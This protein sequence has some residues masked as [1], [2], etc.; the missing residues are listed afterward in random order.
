[1][2]LN[3]RQKWQNISL[4]LSLVLSIYLIFWE[5]P[6]HLP[7]NQLLYS[8]LE[9]PADLKEESLEPIPFSSGVIQ[10]KA[11]GE[12][13]SPSPET[14]DNYL[15]VK[16]EFERRFGNSYD[17]AWK[18]EPKV[19]QPFEVP[20][21]LK[22][23]VDFWTFVFGVYGKYQYIF[24]HADDVSI[25]YAAIDLA[26]LDPSVSGLSKEEV[27]SLVNQYL[28]EEKTRIRK[29]LVHIL[30]TRFGNKEPLTPDEK[31]I[32]KLLSE[33]KLID[34]SDAAD[35]A[36][37]RIQGGFAHRFK[38]A[39]VLS[40]QYMDEM[41]RIFS[42]K[43][44][45]IE[46]TR[47]P[48]VESAFNIEAVSSAQAVGLWQFIPET[49]KR[50]LKIDEIADERKDPILSTYAA[51]QHLAKEYEMLGSWPL[52]INAYNTG[53][54]RMLKAMKAYNTTDIATIIK[55]FGDAG[56]K[57]YSRNYYP[58]FLAALE[59]YNQQEKYFGKIEK[60]SAL[61]YDLF[62][63]KD[64]MNLAKIFVEIDIAP[65]VMRALNPALKDEILEGTKDLPPG[66]LVRVPKEMATLFATAAQR[67]EQ[68]KDRERWYIA[69]E[70]ET[71]ELIAQKHTMPLKILESA[72]AFLPQQRLAEGTVVNIPR[73]EGVAFTPVN[74]SSL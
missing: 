34:A 9:K 14:I 28:A 23:M 42:L 50:Y 36:Q 45:P 33:S 30:G 44:L 56:Y 72:N 1:M 59:V 58:E 5:I 3:T 62:L 74:D 19:H 53:P 10:F 55:N 67:N 49:G 73:E 71:L 35:P 63:P 29:K 13:V 51:T 39:I 60:M 18:Y 66:Y 40:G 37:M 26:S 46:L 68:E 41:E 2:V 22:P 24:H 7:S 65:E 52:T 70:G 38:Q 17:D 25:V 20:P 54:G 47:I 12:E 15:S 6:R 64:R 27:D 69:Q 8:A 48:L 61:T 11:S 4:I 32:A 16:E 21:G 31:R 57:F 43:N